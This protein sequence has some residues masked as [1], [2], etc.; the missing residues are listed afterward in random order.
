[1]SDGHAGENAGPAIFLQVQHQGQGVVQGG[2]VE[3]RGD[4]LVALGGQQ[5]HHQGVG[6]LGDHTGA[7]IG[8]QPVQGADQIVVRLI[9]QQRGQLARVLAGECH[10]QRVGLR[11]AFSPAP[12][13][14]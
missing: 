4:A 5:L 8:G 3:P 6:Q 7:G 13:R 14:W 9:S 1:M 10:A 11:H 12:L 2:A